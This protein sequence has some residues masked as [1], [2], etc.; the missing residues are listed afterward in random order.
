[1]P[2]TLLD[3]QYR[4]IHIASHDSVFDGW[5]VIGT[6]LTDAPVTLGAVSLIEEA[7]AIAAY[8]DVALSVADEVRTQMQVHGRI[9]AAWRAA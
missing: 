3:V 6:R 9:Q 4:R 1:M 7:E 5:F 8:Y 2:D